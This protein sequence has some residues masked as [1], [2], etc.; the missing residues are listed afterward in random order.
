[1]K[2]LVITPILILFGI[3]LSIFAQKTPV[4][5]P[6]LAQKPTSSALIEQVKRKYAPDRRTALFQIGIDSGKVVG[7]TNL[8][9]AKQ[10]LLESFKTNGYTFPDAI[11]MLPESELG[12]E[13]YGFINVS[14][15]NL[16]SGPK[17][18]NEMAS[19]ALLGTPIKVLE[20]AKHWYL[21]QT[22]D[23]YI[24]WIDHGGIERMTK[25]EFDN[26]SKKPKLIYNQPFGFSYEKADQESQT[27]SDLVWGDL[28]AVKDTVENFYQVIY[29]D[30]RKA[31]V[32]KTEV[33]FY[34]EW[35]TSLKV[36]E[37][38]LVKSAYKMVGIPYL[39][40]GTSFKGV[41]CSG[42]TRTVY[43]MNGLYLPRDASQ[44]VYAGELVDT[45]NGFEN[46]KAGDLLFFGEKAHD[47]KSEH[48]SH[49]GMWLGNM[50]FIHSSGMVKIGSFDKNST[51]FDAFNL[52]RYI[53]SKRILGNQNGIISLKPKTV[54]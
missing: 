47:E 17:D 54:F 9:Q 44:Q 34:D 53:K 24:A 3:N 51:K 31:F 2:S 27:V 21:I 11:K 16:R 45:S 10:A 42:F 29:P 25:W 52:G 38:S 12:E 1:M 22:P 13:F 20:K 15:A 5:A 33:K 4:T 48:I 49:V 8:P 35:L 14:V 46:M 40:G 50:Q 18:P 32:A 41:D 43:L 37:N 36:S 23:K 6:A 30:G 7:K 26:Y 39:W 28:L 19:Q